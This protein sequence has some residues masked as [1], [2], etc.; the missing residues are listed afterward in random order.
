MDFIR[1]DGD[2]LFW[3]FLL[4]YSNFS[5]EVSVCL[6]SEMCSERLPRVFVVVRVC[7]ADEGL[8]GDCNA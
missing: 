2:L 4:S 1:C 3:S 6:G 7:I 5:G 8:W